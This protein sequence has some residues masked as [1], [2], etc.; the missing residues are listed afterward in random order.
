MQ[1]VSNKSLHYTYTVQLGLHIKGLS[2]GM[3]LRLREYRLLT[4]WMPWPRAGPLFHPSLC[5]Y[6]FLVMELIFPCPFFRSQWIC[7]RMKRSSTNWQ[8]DKSA[9]CKTLWLDYDL[10]GTDA[11]TSSLANPYVESCV[12]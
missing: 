3:D 12:K 9:S 2:E 4:L 6:F 7:T 5:K 10:K 8:Q 11:F 1:S